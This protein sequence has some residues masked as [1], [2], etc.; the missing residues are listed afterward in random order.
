M[1]SSPITG[2]GEVTPLLTPDVPFG[3]PAFALSDDQIATVL[4]LL[5]K[6]CDEAKAHLTPGM[7]EVPTTIVVRKAMRRVKKTLRLTNLQIR[8]EHELENM[9]TDDP[10]ILGRID[11]TL[12]FLHQFGDE[13]AYV[14]VECKRVHSGDTGL[15][16]SYVAKGVERFATGRY[17]AGH[18]WGF[19]LGYVLALPASTIVDAVDARIRKT[20]GEPAG[21]TA[22]TSHSLALAVLEGA[23]VQKG[24]H[25]IRLKHVFV[26]MTLAAP[27]PLTSRAAKPLG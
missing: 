1:S 15:N 27:P 19:M 7:L 21:L 24:S 26:D 6:G 3:I 18:E 10:A 20:Y 14:A 23:L 25:V 16:A 4:D 11:I 2:F 9:A 12:Q 5:C 8:G 22:E 17:A 13:D